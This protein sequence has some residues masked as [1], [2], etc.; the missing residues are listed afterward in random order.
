VSQVTITVKS[1][2]FL[3][4]TILHLQK[5]YR[6]IFFQETSG[7]LMVLQVVTTVDPW[8]GLKEDINESIKIGNGDSM[9]ARLKI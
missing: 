7:F 1:I 4:K 6:K 3:T 5:S 9:K 2:N 8:K